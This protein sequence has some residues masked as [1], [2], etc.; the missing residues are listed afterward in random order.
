MGKTIYLIIVVSPLKVFAQ[1]NLDRFNSQL[2]KIPSLLIDSDKGGTRD[3][4]EIKKHF[5]KRLILSCTYKSIE[6]LLKR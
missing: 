3:I 5:N 6:M 2:P 4:E 1:Q